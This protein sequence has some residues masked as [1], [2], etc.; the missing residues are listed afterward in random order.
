MLLPDP[1]E[2]PVP[3]ARLDLRGT[4]CPL[5]FIRSRLALEKL[6]SGGWLQVHIDEG[7][8]ERLVAEGLRGEGHAVRILP[9]DLDSDTG[10]RLL[11]RR[12]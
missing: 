1:H 9:R 2:G 10:V 8:P 11:I 7:E 3:Q 4:P 12:G 5:N 6:P